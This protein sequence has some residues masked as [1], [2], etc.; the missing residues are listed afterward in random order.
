MQ[1]V[2]PVQ[3]VA[4]DTINTPRQTP[5]SI[6]DWQWQGE[7]L[8]KVGDAVQWKWGDWWLAGQSE[9][10]PEAVDSVLADLGLERRTLD[11]WADVAACYQPGQR[12]PAVSWTA[13]KYLISM[14]PSDR[15]ALLETAVAE[16]WSSRDILTARE[17]AVTAAPRGA[18]P[19]R[20]PKP[21]RKATQSDGGPVGQ[22]DSD[23][24]RA[25]PVDNVAGSDIATNEPM[26]S[27]NWD[28][29]TTVTLRFS[30]DSIDDNDAASKAQQ[31][32]A[33]SDKLAAAITGRV[34]FNV[35]AAGGTITE[36]A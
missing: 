33:L 14:H 3:P 36:G 19:Q 18:H 30:F 26:V 25:T 4:V 28:G 31:V 32:F 1:E 27:T 2:E 15:Q 23:T 5:Q 29:E 10:A 35:A 11:R 13:H 6:E 9:F 7:Q 12:H 8:R 16:S 24:D 21:T 17:R 34:G 20:K 22:P